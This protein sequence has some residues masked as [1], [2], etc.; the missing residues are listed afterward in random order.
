MNQG[1]TF[2][3]IDKNDFRLSGQEAGNKLRIFRKFKHN[4]SHENY[5]KMKD[6]YTNKMEKKNI[7]KLRI[8]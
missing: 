5:L 2:N 1:Q 6:P 4:I 3:D 8:T 7:V